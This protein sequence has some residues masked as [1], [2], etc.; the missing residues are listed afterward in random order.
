[1]PKKS[2]VPVNDLRRTGGEIIDRV[3]YAKERVVVTKNGKPFVAI[4]SME[5]L[6]ALECYDCED[7]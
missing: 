7:R 3:H 2:E 5:D 4:V 1:M 6:A